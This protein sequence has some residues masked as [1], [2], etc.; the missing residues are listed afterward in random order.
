MRINGLKNLT[1]IMLRDN[2]AEDDGK[3]VVNQNDVKTIGIFSSCNFKDDI[4]GRRATN[5]KQQI[6]HSI[7]FSEGNA[8]SIK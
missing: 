1:E 6:N 3:N 7:T 4:D 5:T 2:N 8:V